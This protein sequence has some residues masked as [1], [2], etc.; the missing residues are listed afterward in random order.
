MTVNGWK[1]KGMGLLYKPE[2]IWTKTLNGK[3]VTVIQERVSGK[4]T[5]EGCLLQF[6]SWDEATNYAEVRWGKKDES[7]NA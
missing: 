1:Q 6:Q 5:I 7:C 4:C 3:K 2:V